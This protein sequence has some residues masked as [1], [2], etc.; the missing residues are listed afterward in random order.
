MITVRNEDALEFTARQFAN[1]EAFCYLDPPYYVKGSKLYRNFY[2]HQ[3]HCSIRELLERN[4][5]G[6]W[7]VSYD[8]VPP[9]RSIYS[10]F[11]P[12]TYS[13]TY[14]AGQKGSRSEVV[15]LATHSLP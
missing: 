4:R 11:E 2:E 15:Y 13:L 7:V 14:S 6:R 10:A 5:S 12:I 1:P 9:I 8:D 3:D